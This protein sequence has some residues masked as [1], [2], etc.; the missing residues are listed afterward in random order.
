MVLDF[1]TI[2]CLIS[3]DWINYSLEEN[4]A[5]TLF[6]LLP[7]NLALVLIPLHCTNSMQQNCNRPTDAI[8]WE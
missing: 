6:K 3:L 5:H 2:A 1:I 7:A 4:H 8:K